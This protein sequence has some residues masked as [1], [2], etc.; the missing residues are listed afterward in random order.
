M[1]GRSL[2]EIQRIVDHYR[3][4][5]DSE[6]RK[7]FGAARYMNGGAH[8]RRSPDGIMKAQTVE[9]VRKDATQGRKPE[10]SWK[11]RPF[12]NFGRGYFI[13]NTMQ[14]ALFHHLHGPLESA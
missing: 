10:E 13:P 8:H 3:K 9:E 4:S 5:A 6:A 1:V 7:V 12:T 11:G 2:E 14:A